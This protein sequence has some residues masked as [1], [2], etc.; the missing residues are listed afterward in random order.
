MNYTEIQKTDFKDSMTSNVYDTISLFNPNITINIKELL[1]SIKVN[2]G[3]RLIIPK[4]I[5]KIKVSG[6]VLAP[7]TFFYLSKLSFNDAVNMGG[8]YQEQADIK[9]A[10][11]VYPNGTSQR[12]KK[13]TGCF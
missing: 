4:T 3:D 8:G 13:N 5:E 12:V 1:E 6:A 2:P 7:N 10:F 11:V 9:N